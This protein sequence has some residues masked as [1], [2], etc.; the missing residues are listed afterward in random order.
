MYQELN[1]LDH[2]DINTVRLVLVI[3]L[4]VVIEADAIDNSK[5]ANKKY[6]E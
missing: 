5:P 2:L 1:L 3:I 4:G 6:L